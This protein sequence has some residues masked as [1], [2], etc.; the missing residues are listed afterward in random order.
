MSLR[1]LYDVPAPA[2]LNLFL[3]VRGRRPDG[4]HLLESAFMLIDWFDTL[5][6][7]KRGDGQV[8]RHDL[9]APLPPTDLCL[10]AALMLKTQTGC[11][12]GVDISVLKRIPAQAGLGGGSSD[13]ATTLLALNRL[14]DLRLSQKQLM[15]T[16][17]AL[18]A[19]IPFFLFGQNA[20]AG[21]VGEQL[22]E[23][24]LPHA[25]WLVIKPDQGLDTGR[26]FSD[27]A[28]RRDTEAAIIS[29]F[30]ENPYCYGRND[31]QQV[32][33]PHCR[34]VRTALSWLESVGLQ[35]RMTG[36]GSAVF[37]QIPSDSQIDMTGCPYGYR[38]CENLPA[39]PLVAWAQ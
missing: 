9:G 36:S 34:G 32:A 29:D 8:K 7:E 39:H 30:A 13:A 17:L 16:G 12:M 26:I 14:W 18:G 22:Q 23:I 33:E 25:R 5:H 27:P 11:P 35:G 3:H 2:K 10:K 15:E 4:Y 28:L 37:A 19:D 20:W 21:G 1:A 38:L 24:E 31:L 6:F